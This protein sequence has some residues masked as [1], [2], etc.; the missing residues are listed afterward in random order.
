[1]WTLLGDIFCFILCKNEK[2]IYN[3]RNDEIV[4]GNVFNYSSGDKYIVMYEEPGGGMNMLEICNLTKKYDKEKGIFD[5]SYSFEEGKIYALVGPNG[6]GKTTLIQMISG[7]SEPMKGQ[8]RLDDQDTLLRKSKSQIGYALELTGNNTKQTVLQFLRMVCDI[9][10]G[11]EHKE[12]IMSFLTDFELE[13]D[14][15]TRL[16]E[17]SLGMK[18]KVGI[19]ASFIGFPKLIL[20]DEPTNGVDTTG[21]IVLKKYIESAREHNCIVIISSHVL[22]FVD[23]VKDEIIFLKKGHLVVGNKATTEEQYRALFM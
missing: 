9:K 14:K 15:D 4:C 16:S 7:I 10:F 17:C 13:D 19:I 23:S 12:D 20:L 21:L 6:A 2:K 3:F 5:L 18:K 8:I 1:M 22:D 11:G